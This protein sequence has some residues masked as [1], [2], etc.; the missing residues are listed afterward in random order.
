MDSSGLEEDDDWSRR[1][2]QDES[3]RCSSSVM[4]MDGEQDDDD[5]DGGIRSNVSAATSIPPN[6]TPATQDMNMDNSLNMDMNMGEPNLLAPQRE[7]PTLKEKLVER[8][9]QRRVETEMARLKR[10][11]ALSSSRNRNNNNNNNG[12]DQ[13]DGQDNDNDD[14]TD[15]NTSINRGGVGVRAENGSAQGTVGDESTISVHGGAGDEPGNNN[16]KEGE[17]NKLTYPMERFLQQ[18]GT[19]NQE[20]SQQREHKRENT[21]TQG[22]VMERFLKDPIVVES[23]PESEPERRISDLDPDPDPDPDQGQNNNVD[24]T[25]SFNVE[26]TRAAQSQVQ[27]HSNPR[28]V[29]GASGS[30]D[31]MPSGRS[32]LSHDDGSVGGVLTSM[33]SMEAH[34]SVEANTPSI[35]N[36]HDDSDDSKH[37]DELPQNVGPSSVTLDSLEVQQQQHHHPTNEHEPYNNPTADRTSSTISSEQQQQPPRVLRLT[38]AE[39]QE[40]AAIEEVSTGNAPPSDRDDISE[41]SFVGEL[42]TDFGGGAPNTLSQGTPTTAMESASMLE[43]NRSAPPSIDHEHGHDDH[44]LDDIATGS[45]ASSDDGNSVSVVANPPSERATSERGAGEAPLSPSIPDEMHPVLSPTQTNME[46]QQQQQEN[47]SPERQLLLQGGGGGVARA[48]PQMMGVDDGPLDLETSLAANVGVV[49][50]QI[51]PGMINF[52]PH[53]GGMPDIVARSPASPV[54]RTLSMPDMLTFDVDGFDYDKHAPLS[55]RSGLSDSIRDFPPDDVWSP[56]DH[57]KMA[58][59]PLHATRKRLSMPSPPS[60]F[61]LRPDVGG[62]TRGY[63]TLGGV[64]E[65][66]TPHLQFRPKAI[67]PSLDV[68]VQDGQPEKDEGR[69]LLSQVPRDIPA[70]RAYVRELLSGEIP[71]RSLV[72]DVFSDIRSVST[73]TESLQ[74]YE[75]KEYLETNILARGELVSSEGLFLFVESLHGRI[76]T[77]FYLLFS[78]SRTIGCSHSHFDD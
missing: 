76:K 40:M 31:S 68:I 72:D 37:V 73:A 49:N 17:P 27:A 26:P 9:R 50:R 20:Q 47:D 4:A 15:L 74:N 34:A 75:A 53:R 10:Q 57:G 59:S 61:L 66:E 13:D 12:E 78:L 16:N 41:S 56:L 58:V 18:Q 19:V 77:F 32:S 33:A 30:F 38:E 64:L 44:S 42:N 71:V 36:D 55:P 8:E 23:E 14:D 2:E 29:G 11:F 46:Q 25:V 6:G 52:K 65:E 5:D 48:P 35:H 7:E 67:A 28:I 45:E 60:N 21:T 51:R 54:R 43:S 69:P 24:R 63:G 3:Q 1:V 22:V 62:V 39:I 70:G